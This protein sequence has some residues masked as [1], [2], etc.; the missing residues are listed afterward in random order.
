MSAPALQAVGA[1]PHVLSVRRPLVTPTADPRR[2]VRVMRSRIARRITALG[3][4]LVLLCLVQVWLRLQVVDV[5]YQLSAARSMLD[6]LDHEHRQ[7]RAEIATLQDAGSL[8]NAAR[9]KAGLVEPQ[10][11]QVIELR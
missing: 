2:L 3:A 5:G 11:G 1:A 6:R 10:K 4:V 8:A 9:A 7:L